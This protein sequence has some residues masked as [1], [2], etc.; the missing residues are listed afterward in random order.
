MQLVREGD[1]VT[2]AE[3]E[4]FRAGMASVTRSV[5]LG[6]TA[7]YEM[8]RDWHSR[9]LLYSMACAFRGQGIVVALPMPDPVRDRVSGRL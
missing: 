1:P 4:A 7:E 2:D 5:Q 3:A 9:A 8:R 6:L